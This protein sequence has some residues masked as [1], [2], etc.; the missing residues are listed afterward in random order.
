MSLWAEFQNNQE[1][2]IFKWKHYFPVY[3]RHFQRFVNRP[4][5]F[6]EVGVGQ[7]GSLQMWKRYLGPHAQIVGL[8][9]EPATAQ[10]AEDQ[11]DVRIG[12]QADTSFLQAV[13]EELGTP[14]VIIDDG[15]HKMC[16]I[17]ATFQWM[18]PRMSPVGVYLVEDLH[19]AYWSEYGGGLG[20]PESFIE[21]S[22]S[23]VDQLNVDQIRD[24]TFVRSDFGASTLSMHFYP[25]V[26][27]FERGRHLLKSAQTT[28][29]ERSE[30]GEMT[31]GA[32]RLDR[33]RRRRR[34]LLA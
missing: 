24:E 17:T 15:S 6:W 30:G 5:V 16:D 27:V 7:G 31:E 2:Q 19:A 20:H 21:L 11:I 22:K 32:E 23:L 8:D 34:R 33:T 1:R 12:A 18:Y 9:I 28:G 13:S 3:E 14:D 25:S 26:V 29:G 4:C 10:F